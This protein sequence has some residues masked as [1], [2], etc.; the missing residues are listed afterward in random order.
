MSQE[1]DI[2]EEIRIIGRIKKILFPISQSLTSLKFLNAIFEKGFHNILP[3]TVIALR[4][5]V[6]IPVS[7][8]EGE[9]TFS[10]LNLIKTSLRSTMTEQRL[11][12]LTLLSCEHDLAK[13]V[14]YDNVIESFARRKARKVK[15]L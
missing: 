14:N 2:V 10:K 11:S 15:L 13:K 7:V 8:A 3:Q 9:R 1:D 5:F 6:A 12:A 4:I